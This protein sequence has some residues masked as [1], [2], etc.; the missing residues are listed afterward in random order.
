MFKYVAIC[1]VSIFLLSCTKDNSSIRMTSI[2]NPSL[3][4]SQCS[5]LV[6]DKEGNVYMSWVEMLAD[7]SYQ[8]LMSPLDTQNNT[9]SQRVIIV[10]GKDWFVNWADMPGIYPF[11]NGSFF[12]YWLEMSS[13]ETY[14]YDIKYSIGSPEKGWSAPQTFHNDGISAEHGFVSIAP[15][16]DQLILSW[17][18]GR[19]TKIKNHNNEENEDDHGHGHSGAMT[20]RTAIIDKDGT[21]TMRTQVDQRICDC[22][23]TD[24]TEGLN[25]PIVVYRDRS[26][27]EIRDIYMSRLVD[28][29][30]TEPRP[31]HTDYW[32][33]YGCPVNGPAIASF[34]STVAVA[35]YTEIEGV[36]KTQLKWSNDGGESYH[37]PIDIGTNH[38][39]GRVD[40]ELIKKDKALVT[41]MKSINKTGEIVAS[42]I[43]LNTAEQQIIH[44]AEN[45]PARKSG[46]PKIL[47]TDTKVLI[48]YTDALSESTSVKTSMIRLND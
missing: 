3:S 9:F 28:E 42:I 23:Q 31:I 37:S 48:S 11:S 12:A 8:L 20:L 33:I 6:K 17:L 21:I 18:D 30:W 29:K 46:F 15:Y 45:S 34:D 35:W 5:R 40:I 38:T 27:A 4:Q 44:I 41:W 19:M 14:D 10:K 16:A 24:I 13:P 36:S 25:G 22:C 32:K 2:N 7:T 47:Y 39:L 26:Q 1:I 43:D